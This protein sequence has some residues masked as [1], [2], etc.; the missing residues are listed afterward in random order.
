M[1]IMGVKLY[2]TVVWVCISLVTNDVERLFTCL[3]AICGSSLEKYLPIVCPIFNVNVLLIFHNPN[4]F[5]LCTSRFSLSL[6]LVVV[7]RKAF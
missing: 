3:L 4:I 5:K 2:L 7:M 1:T 6:S